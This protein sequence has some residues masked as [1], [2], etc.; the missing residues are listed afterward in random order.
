[1]LSC[2]QAGRSEQDG[3]VEYSFVARDM[4][5]RVCTGYKHDF[6]DTSIINMGD[7]ERKAADTVQKRLYELAKP[8]ANFP[9]HFRAQTT[10]TKWTNEPPRSRSS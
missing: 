1:M 6:A 8:L 9:G 7:T 10:S 2:V 5:I 3:T 4:L